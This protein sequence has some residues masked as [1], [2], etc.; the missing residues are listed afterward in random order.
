M[1]SYTRLSDGGRSPS[2]EPAFNPPFSSEYDQRPT[3]RLRAWWTER[4]GGTP[5]RQYPVSGY[6]TLI[7]LSGKPAGQLPLTCF[8]GLATYAAISFFCDLPLTVLSCLCAADERLKPR[9]TKLLV[10]GLVCLRKRLCLDPQACLTSMLDPHALYHTAV[11]EA[12]P[13]LLQKQTFCSE[14]SCLLQM[15]FS[16]LAAVGVFLLVPRGIS[17]GGVEIQ[18]DHMSW[19]TTRG[20]Y[21]LKLLAKIPIYNPNYMKVVLPLLLCMCDWV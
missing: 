2:N 16:V 15:L 9:R 11:H 20:T 10:G 14:A 12:K 21:Q 17:V 19:N 1:E 5:A 13:I 8:C 7:P 3:N 6:L 4:M 18:S